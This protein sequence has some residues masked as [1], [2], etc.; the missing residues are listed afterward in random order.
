MTDLQITDLLAERVMGWESADSVWVQ[1]PGHA[2]SLRWRGPEE[3]NHGTWQPLID[4][5]HAFQVVARMQGDGWFPSLFDVI[6]LPEWACRFHTPW[7]GPNKNEDRDV[8]AYHK[9]PT[10]AICLAA[11]MALGVEVPD[12]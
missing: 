11:L 4:K 9:E 8:T 6:E 3:E 7:A 10:R 12:A 2:V 5:N 1:P